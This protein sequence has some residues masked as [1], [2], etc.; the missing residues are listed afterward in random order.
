MIELNRRRCNNCVIRK[1]CAGLRRPTNSAATPRMTPPTLNLARLCCAIAPVGYNMGSSA[2]GGEFFDLKPAVSSRN[3][4]FRLFHEFFSIR[5]GRFANLTCLFNV[6]TGCWA[7]NPAGGRL[8]RPV[9]DGNYQFDAETGSL[10]GKRRP[11]G[12]K[13]AVLE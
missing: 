3:S 10:A 7:L 11:A 13:R 4:L 6:E 1:A 8:N 2:I 12:S 5:N 9:A